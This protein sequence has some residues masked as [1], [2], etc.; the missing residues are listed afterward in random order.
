MNAVNNE[1]IYSIVLQNVR[2]LTQ[3]IESVEL[4]TAFE[5]E[6]LKQS[7]NQPKEDMKS[8]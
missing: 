5:L 4:F 3:G 7:L 8:A 6:L 1:S 2:S